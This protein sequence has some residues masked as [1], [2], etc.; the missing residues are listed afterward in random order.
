MPEDRRLLSPAQLPRYNGSVEA[1]NG[2]LKTHT[3]HQAVVHGRG[4]SPTSDD[5]EA[6]RQQLNATLRPWGPCRPTPLEAWQSR[7]PIT[8]EQPAR[9][10]Q[11]VADSRQLLQR[12]LGLGD[13]PLAPKA[14]AIVARAAIRRALETLGYLLVQRRRITPPF[15]SPLRDKIT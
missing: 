5:V 9:F 11:C 3:Y 10:R 13:G 1:G 2:S 12:A 7:K 6:A 4:D 15:N 14:Q 8:P